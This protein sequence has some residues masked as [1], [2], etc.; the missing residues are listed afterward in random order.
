[1]ASFERYLTAI[2][3]TGVTPITAA[4]FTLP[5]SCVAEMK[6][7]VLARTS[8]GV[9]AVFKI[10]GS[11]GRE[12]AGATLI[13]TALDIIS[14]RKDAGATTWLAAV[15]ITGNDIAVEITGQISTTIDWLIH[16]DVIIFVP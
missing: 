11:A 12:G 13:S 1:M 16:A 14:A 2:R 4:N 10:F 6:A 3:T 9:R 15:V 5:A 7:D 8:G